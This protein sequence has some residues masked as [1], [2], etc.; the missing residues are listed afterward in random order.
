MSRSN[1]NCV[2]K[3]AQRIGLAV[4]AMKVAGNSHPNFLTPIFMNHCPK[5]LIF[6]PVTPVKQLE[7]GKRKAS[8]TRLLGIINLS[9]P[10]STRNSTLWP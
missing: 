5:D 10:L 1:P 7:E 3:S 4:A 9:A 8:G 6:D 2:K